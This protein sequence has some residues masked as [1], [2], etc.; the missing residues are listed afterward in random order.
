[1]YSGRIARILASLLLISICACCS[2]ALPVQPTAAGQP[3]QA[4][5]PAKKAPRIS[6]PVSKQTPLAV[7]TPGSLPDKFNIILGRPTA[8][9]VTASLYARADTQVTI[10]W[11]ESGASTLQTLSVDLQADQPRAIELTGLKPDTAYIYTIIAD[12]TPAGD[13]GFH[14]QRAPGSAFTFTIDADPHNRDPR[15]NGALYTAALSAAHAS[16]PD[17]HIDLGDTFMTE[18]IK[19]Q[20]SQAVETVYSEMRPYFALLAAD[21]PLFL[22]NGNHDG[23]MGWL[24]SAGKNGALPIW[25]TSARQKYY[26]NPQPDDFYSGGSTPD[27]ALGSPRDGYYSWTWGDA[28]FVVLDPFWYTVTKPGVGGPTEGWNWT[29]GREQYD[30]LKTVLADSDAPLKFVFI[31]HLVGGAAPEARGGVEFASLYEWGGNNADGSYGF[32]DQRPGWGEPIHR[33]LVENRVSA[34]FHGHDHVYVA[35]Q[36]DGIVYQEVPQPNVAGGHSAQLAEE[37]GYQSGS[38]LNGAGILQVQVS[39]AGAEVTLVHACL[40]E[41]ENSAWCS[42]QQPDTYH[43]AP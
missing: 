13:H 16:N 42:T 2:P 8:D 31:H 40:P 24:L 14:T 6:T 39:S 17:F 4:S 33:L 3:T 38:I 18:K 35:Q 36:L 5:T 11:G 22:V 12:G 20:T 23:E 30:W 34:V 26:P 43:I 10:R 29:L 25:S 7:S 15:F 1:M 21:S 27:P 28:L 41:E 9:S 19:A 32:D 37:Y